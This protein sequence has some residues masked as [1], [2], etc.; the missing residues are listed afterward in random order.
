MS[1]FSLA[2][3]VNSISRL[4]LATY[5]E[6]RQQCPEAVEALKEANGDVLA[7][8]K[9]HKDQKFRD[10]I[11]ADLRTVD[12]LASDLG[13]EMLM[14]ELQYKGAPLPDDFRKQETTHD[15]I[16][17]A[18][19]NA[20]AKLK[21]ANQIY[22]AERSA[23]RSWEHR[24]FP[25]T[26]RNGDRRS[27]VTEAHAEEVMLR[28]RNLLVEAEVR[29]MTQLLV[30]P[31]FEDGNTGWTTSSGVISNQGVPR[32][33]SFAAW[34]CG[35]GS[36]HTDTLSQAVT[37]PT[38]ASSATLSFYLHVETDETLPKSF[39]TLTVQALDSGGNVLSVLGTFSN[40]DASSGYVQKTFDLSAFKGQTVQISVVG[41]EDARKATSFFVDD[42]TVVTQ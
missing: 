36:K 17:W 10:A 34:L 13:V 28:T 8:L 14:A 39:D 7:V 27:H 25:T 12:E 33:G 9:G 31:G 2:R 24:A 30:N 18:M 32:G 16:M 4:L 3:V 21:K 20:E 42:C 26:W 40:M 6:T 38:S 29:G 1:Q 23:R 35:Y 41:K 15:R 19:L 11:E 5:F 37:I 22:D